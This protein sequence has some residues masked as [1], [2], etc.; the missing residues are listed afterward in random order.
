M[1]FSGNVIVVENESI[2]HFTKDMVESQG[3]EPLGSHV[4][5]GWVRADP[6]I[7]RR[8]TLAGNSGKIRKNSGKTGKI[9]KMQVTYQIGTCPNQLFE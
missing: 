7:T 2:L 3:P 6:G 8:W 4:G 5:Y 1:I 9:R